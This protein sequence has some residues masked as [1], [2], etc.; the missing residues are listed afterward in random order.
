M[1]ENGRCIIS[2]KKLYGKRLKDCIKKTKVAKLF[3][4]YPVRYG[5][6]ICEG[7]KS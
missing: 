7:I 4:D 2:N 1:G 5:A 3:R 6:D